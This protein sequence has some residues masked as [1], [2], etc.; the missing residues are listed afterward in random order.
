MLEVWARN[1]PDDA[2]RF[3][4]SVDQHIANIRLTSEEG[5]VTSTF[6]DNRLFF[7][8]ETMGDDF[9][10]HPEWRRYVQPIRDQPWGRTRVPNWPNDSETAKAWLRGSIAEH[11]CPFAWLFRETFTPLFD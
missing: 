4:N 2:I 10:S 5:L 7:Q 3:P 6:G 9:D 11:E 8:H 1:D